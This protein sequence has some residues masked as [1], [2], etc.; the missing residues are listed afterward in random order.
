MGYCRVVLVPRRDIDDECAGACIPWVVRVV[1]ISIFIFKLH[2]QCLEIS[3]FALTL[4]GVGAKFRDT[5]CPQVFRSKKEI[6]TAWLRNLNVGHA[7]RDVLFPCAFVEDVNRNINS[8]VVA[9]IK[10][11]DCCVFSLLSRGGNRTISIQSNNPDTKRC[12]LN[13]LFPDVVVGS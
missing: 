11:L 7:Q 3:G 12:N 2:G 8:S 5:F 10:D 1:Q 9:H 13:F 6:R 4:H